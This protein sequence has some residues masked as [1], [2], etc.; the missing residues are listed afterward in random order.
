[1]VASGLVH[2]QSQVDARGSRTCFPSR[3]REHSMNRSLLALIV[4]VSGFATSSARAQCKIANIWVDPAWGQDISGLAADAYIDDPSM[5]CRTLQFAID[6]M[7]QYL[8]KA[9]FDNPDIEGVVHAMPGLY[10]PHGNYSSGDQFP[11]WMHDRV[12]VQGIGAR[13]CVIRG[14]GPNTFGTFWP[15]GQVPQ[16]MDKKVLVAFRD[17]SQFS[18]MRSA[19]GTLE[20]PSVPE[21]MPP[22]AGRGETA[23]LIDGFTFQGGDVQ[24][25]VC[26]GYQNGFNVLGGGPLAAR[27][28]N[29][30]FDMRHQWA[31]SEQVDG[32]PPFATYSVDGPWF[33]VLMAKPHYSLGPGQP[34]GYFEEEVLIASNTFILAEWRLGTGWIHTARSD[35][36]AIMDV[37]DPAPNNG[38]ADL[39]TQLRGLGNPIIINNLIRTWPGV[40][41]AS[42]G[43][44]AMLGIERTDTR[45]IDLNNAPRDTNAF[46]PSRVGTTN[47]TFRSAPVQRVQTAVVTLSLGGTVYTVGPLFNCT[48]TPAGAP[49]TVTAAPVTAVVLWDGSTSS[50]PAPHDPAFVGE[51]LTTLT[52]VVP[53]TYR[54]WRLLPESP[55]IDAGWYLPGMTFENGSTRFLP[56]TACPQIESFDWDAEGYGNPR[57]VSGAIDIGCDEVHMLIMGGSYANDSTAHNENMMPKA[58]LHPSAVDG[59]ATRQLITLQLFAGQ[60]MQINGT[61]NSPAS[62]P[63]RLPMWIQPPVTL[64]PSTVDAGAVP[65][66]HVRYISQSN[67]APAPTPWAFPSMG[68]TTWNLGNFMG[69]PNPTP[70]THNF[71]R[72]SLPDNECPQTACSHSYFNTQALV[73]FGSP[74]ARYLS[75]LQVE[76]R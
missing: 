20:V 31:A 27:I 36:V 10:G 25:Y 5:A 72:V 56:G 7:G 15:T 59:V 48:S 60:A 73:D 75:N 22:W 57:I 35:A 21:H 62:Q 76:F 55:L 67:P 16:T 52:N 14:G 1:M 24:V 51:Y 58:H 69:M 3:Y 9:G 38:I 47:G 30:V 63:P 28:T 4:L 66:Y 8:R 23:E 42:S 12:H 49:C 45:I 17:S 41:P 19:T 13:Q 34:D 18:R 39:N 32:T 26:P 33:G 43:H 46:V 50:S 64:V 61:M 29:C 70:Q 11:I 2:L 53:P 40:Q 71:V 6:H 65:G 74:G 68:L 37:V 54:D 44:M